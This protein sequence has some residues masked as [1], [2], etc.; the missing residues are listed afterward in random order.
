MQT[1]GRQVS[2]LQKLQKNGPVKKKAD[3]WTR[4]S[5]AG[6]EENIG[7]TALYVGWP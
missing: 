6:K 5:I 1:H 7:M 2:Q 3:K 4:R